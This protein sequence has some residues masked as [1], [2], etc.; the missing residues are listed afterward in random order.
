[1]DTG[2]LE[3]L[4]NDAERELQDPGR[5]ASRSRSFSAGPA[6]SLSGLPEVLSVSL[7]E[8]G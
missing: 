6:S 5:G 7:G 8:P 4:K 2:E 3:R 1:V